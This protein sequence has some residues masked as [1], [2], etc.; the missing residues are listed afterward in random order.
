ML[1]EQTDILLSIYT[2]LFITMMRKDAQNKTESFVS[3]KCNGCFT[4]Q[5]QD[6]FLQLLCGHLLDILQATGCGHLYLH[7]SPQTESHCFAETG[8]SP[9]LVVLISAAAGPHFQLPCKTFKCHQVQLSAGPKWHTTPY[10]LQTL[11]HKLITC[12]Q[13]ADKKPYIYRL[14][15]APCHTGVGCPCIIFLY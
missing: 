13:K 5:W 3:Q 10:S 1:P 12:S 6:P 9:E 15:W 7:N 8:Y 11:L 14:F 2:T 4:S